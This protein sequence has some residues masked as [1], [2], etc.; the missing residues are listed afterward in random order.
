MYYAS[1]G[2][3]DSETRY[4][5]IEKLALA[6]VILARRLR[7]YFQAHTIH[8][9][10]NQP[11]RQVLQKL[12][13]SG[14]PVKWAVELGEFDIHYKSRSSIKGQAAE[15]FISE[16]TPLSESTTLST[17]ASISTTI[18]PSRD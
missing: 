1:N 14:R 6:L 17:G 10:T 3:V 9:L 2:L 11:L 18:E 13:T 7:P 12:E 4:P 16:M 15:D 8:V 5:L